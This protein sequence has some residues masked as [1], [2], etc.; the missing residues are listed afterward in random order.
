[1]S[2][3]S[4]FYIFILDIDLQHLPLHPKADPPHFNDWTCKTQWAHLCKLVGDDPTNIASIPEAQKH[5][6]ICFI[7][8][9]I[10]LPQSQLLD[11]L[12]DLWDLGPDPSLLISNAHIQIF[13]V[14]QLEWWLYIIKPHLSLSLVPWKLAVTDVTTAVMCLRHDWGLDITKITHNL[15]EKAI[16]I[17]TLLPIHVLPHNDHRLPCFRPVYANYIVYEQHH[18]KFMNQPHAKAAL[19]HGGLIWQLALHSLGFN[20]LPSV[21]DGIS[22]EAVPFGLL[23]D[24]NGQTYFDDELLDKE[25]DFMCG[26]YYVHNND[27]NVEIVS[28]WPI[29]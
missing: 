12:P 5:V 15:L 23:L 4:Q 27:G 22:W 2:D 28:W 10:T 17:K 26:T 3:L 24:I 6:I 20:V 13:Y 16:T 1:M 8:Y 14:Q 19:L 29:P 18:H 25:V 11:V 7:G 9:L 21:L